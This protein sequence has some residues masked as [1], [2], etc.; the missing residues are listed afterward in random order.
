VH[1]HVNEA[2]NLIADV[3]SQLIYDLDIGQT[4]SVICPVDACQVLPV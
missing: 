3:P 1:L 2:T 4:I